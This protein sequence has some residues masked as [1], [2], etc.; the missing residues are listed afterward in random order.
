M[1]ARPDF[2]IDAPGVVQAN[3]ALGALFTLIAIAG[4]VWSGAGPAWSWLAVGAATTAGLLIFLAAVML[5]SSM[6][7]KQR[8]C[9]RIVT[10]LA[11]SEDAHVLDA[12]CGRG[13][14]LIACAKT[15][16]TGKAV[17]VDLWAASD[18]SGNTPEAVLTN[19][20]V[21]GVADR[22]EV[23][24]GDITALAFPSASFDAV[25]IHQVLHY[26]DRPD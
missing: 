1:S 12:G 18:L 15:L 8:I 23:R 5:G 14:A 17:G 10:A 9:D 21:A 6:A 25:I 7:G 16:R 24:T 22:I 11:L 2:G 4:V 26:A 20:E 19:A 13:L 3:I